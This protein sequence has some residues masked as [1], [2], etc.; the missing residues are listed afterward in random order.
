MYLLATTLLSYRLLSSIFLS[1]LLSCHFVPSYASVRAFHYLQTKSY[2]RYCLFSCYF[3]PPNP[4]V[5][6]F[7]Y[8]QNS[9]LPLV[10]INAV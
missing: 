5:C 9:T 2:S 1:S 10:P 4:S 8:S 7:S 3:V 6:A